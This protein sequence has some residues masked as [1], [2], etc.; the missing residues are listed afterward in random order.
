MGGSHA[1]KVLSTTTPKKSTTP[2]PAPA[3]SKPDSAKSRAKPTSKPRSKPAVARPGTRTTRPRPR[4][5]APQVFQC[6]DI[7]VRVSRGAGGG[8]VGWGTLDVSF[9]IGAPPP[10]ITP[11]VF[12]NAVLTALQTWRQAVPFRFAESPAGT[13]SVAG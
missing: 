7:R 10:G 13:L 6:R 3:K 11:A 12:R 1:R 8:D 2:R 5:R 4:E 9:T